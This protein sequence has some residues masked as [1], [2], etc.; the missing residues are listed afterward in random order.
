MSYTSAAISTAPLAPLPRKSFPLGA[1]SSTPP[2]FGFYVRRV[3]SGTAGTV[4]FVV[5]DNCGD[6]PTFVGRGPS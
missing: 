5:T 6:W 3:G 1:F 2:T 4:P